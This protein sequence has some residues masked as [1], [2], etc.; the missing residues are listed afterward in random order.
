[1]AAAVGGTEKLNITNAELCAK[2]SLEERP[3]EI[4]GRGVF[5]NVPIPAGALV[6]KFEGPIYDRDTCP[7]FSEAIQVRPRAPDGLSP[8][9]ATRAR[10]VS[11]PR[12]LTPARSR[13][14]RSR[15]WA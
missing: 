2:W 1:M 15:R 6:I 5:P 13:P 4:K 14:L 12:S 3:V 8:R 11:Y 7:D 9:C 10:A